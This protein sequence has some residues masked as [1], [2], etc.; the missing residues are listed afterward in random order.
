MWLITNFGFYSVV[1]KPGDT[2]LTIRGR[3]GED[4]EQLRDRYLPSLGETVE[5][6]GTDYRYRATASHEAVAEALSR[7]AMDI[8]YSNFKDSVAKEQGY[9]RSGVY[10]EVWSA[11]MGLRGQDA[12]GDGA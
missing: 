11:L 9:D 7:I 10:H 12:T 3:V 6:A 2:D 4:L 5:G 8:D 1:Q